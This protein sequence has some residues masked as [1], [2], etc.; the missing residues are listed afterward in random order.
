MLRALVTRDGGL[1]ELCEYGITDRAA[2]AGLI[3]LSRCGRG[4]VC[5]RTATDP[6]TRR[7]WL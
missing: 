7:H 3:A 4:S 2:I 5:G 1:I 6:T